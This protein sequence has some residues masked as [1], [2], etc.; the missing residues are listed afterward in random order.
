MMQHIGREVIKYDRI[1][2]DGTAIEAVENF[3]YFGA[4]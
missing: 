3:K 1:E 2:I 4:T